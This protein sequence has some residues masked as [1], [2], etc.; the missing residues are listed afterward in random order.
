MLYARPLT[1]D[2]VKSAYKKVPSDKGVLIGWDRFTGKAPGGKI[3]EEFY[4]T[5]PF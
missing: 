5:Y 3:T 4:K 2:E 1:I